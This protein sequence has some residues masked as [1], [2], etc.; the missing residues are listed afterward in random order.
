MR[1]KSLTYEL[2]IRMVERKTVLPTCLLYYILTTVSQS[3][4]QVMFK[5]ALYFYPRVEVFPKYSPTLF[6]YVLPVFA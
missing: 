4:V 5:T 2:G 3:T 6:T 1:A